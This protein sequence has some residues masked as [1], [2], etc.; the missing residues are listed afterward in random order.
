MT[1]R[2]RL[3]AILT[4]I[5]LLSS[6]AGSALAVDLLPP[7]ACERLGCQRYWETRLPLAGKEMVRRIALLDDNLYVLTDANSVFAVHSRTGILRWS[8]IVAD[9]GVTV[10]GPSHAAEYVFFTTPGVVRA[11]SRRTGELPS[12]PI[13]LDGFV[14]NVAHDTATLTIGQVDGVR[15]GDIL[16]VYRPI[17]GGELEKQALAQ[18]RITSIDTD[19]SKGRLVSYDKRRRPRSGDR[20]LADVT[21]PLKQVKLPFAASSA[22]VADAS[23]IYVG[24]ANQRFYSLDIRGGFEHWQ[25]LTP[26][27]VSSTPVLSDDA[28]IFAGQDGWVVSC[29]KDERRRNWMF[30]TEGPVFADVLV[31]D[32]HVYVAS[33]DR[34]LYCLDRVTKDPRGH[35]QWRE[36]FDTPLTEAPMVSQGRA[37]Q[38]VPQQGLFVLDARTGKHLWKRPDGG[39]FLVQF[40]GDAYLLTGEGP[41]QIVRVEAKTGLEKA[42]VSADLVAFA[43]GSG[44]DQCILLA[45]RTGEL[46]CLRSN[47]APRLRPAQL[48]EVLRNDGKI[49]IQKELDAKQQKELAKKMRAA[50]VPKKPRSLD[51]FEEDWLRSRRTGR[52]AGGHGLVGVEE[53]ADKP[54]EGEEQEEVE[55]EGDEGLDEEEDYEDEELGEEDEDEELSEEDEDEDEGDEAEDEED[56][57]AEEGDEEDE[58][59]EDDEEDD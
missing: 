8:T 17:K 42:R 28:L 40:E 13:K 57:D 2:A 14:I 29:T 23:R 53:E 21:L 20:V 9:E 31:D 50:P 30:Q 1:S 45:T 19:R 7:S 49:R 16:S 38:S 10:R 56:E 44:G 51:L 24:A 22:A 37:Y 26:R 35:L 15:N 58:E 6:S 47:K 55:G 39:R 12:K 32:K 36:R 4:A 43:A 41:R 54:E 25:L 59:D 52:P 33:S 46:T 11:F 5:L 3:N 27:T 34:S 48:A 18:L